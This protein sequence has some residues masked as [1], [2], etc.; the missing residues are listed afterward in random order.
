M[1]LGEIINQTKY[2]LTM[3]ITIVNFFSNIIFGMVYI[4]KDANNL[5]QKK[6]KKKKTIKYK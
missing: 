4:I 3:N 5:T 1:N 2:L 6:V